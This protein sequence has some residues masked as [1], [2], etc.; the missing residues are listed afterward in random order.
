[1]RA[2]SNIKVRLFSINLSFSKGLRS[3]GLEELFSDI[4]V[5]RWKLLI[6]ATATRSGDATRDF[7][8][9]SFGSSRK[10]L[11]SRNH[12]EDYEDLKLFFSSLSL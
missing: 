3:L 5:L 9:L 10:S 7:L 12:Q 1:M 11:N 4:T 2:L 8:S 6:S